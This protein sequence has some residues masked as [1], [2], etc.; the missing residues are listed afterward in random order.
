MSLK[1]SLILLCK[2]F[3]GKMLAAGD[4]NFMYRMIV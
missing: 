1:Q 2:A 3:I 4:I